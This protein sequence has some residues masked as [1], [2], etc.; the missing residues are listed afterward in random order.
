MLLDCSGEIDLRH[1]TRS[2]NSPSM[3]KDKKTSSSP[4]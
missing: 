4:M 1:A 3:H 2:E